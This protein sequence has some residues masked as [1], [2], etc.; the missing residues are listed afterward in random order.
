MINHVVAFKLKDFQVEE[1]AAARSELKAMLEDLQKYQEHPGHG[2]VAKRLHE[3]VDARA[4]V[5]LK[6]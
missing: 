1:K 6:F 5:D 4:A 3:T 2:K